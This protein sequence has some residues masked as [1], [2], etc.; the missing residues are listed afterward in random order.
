VSHIFRVPLD[1]GEQQ[2]LTTGEEDAFQ[3][4][5]SPDGTL[6]AFG[7]ERSG[8]DAILIM[9]AEGGEPRV[10]VEGSG[11]NDRPR[12]SPDGS[13]VAFM[14]T[15]GG[16][17]GIWV[18]PSEGGEAARVSPEE[19]WSEDAEWSP[20]GSTIA[21]VSDAAGGLGKLMTAPAGGGE[22]TLVVDIDLV[23]DQ[24][25]SPDGQSIVFTAFG[26]GETAQV[27]R[28]YRVSP[29]GGNPVL[30]TEGQDAFQP[31]WSADGTMIAYA[32]SVGEGNRSDIYVMDADGS[33]KRQLTTHP[34]TDM[35]PRWTPDGAHL[36]FATRRNGSWDIGMVP[37][38]GGDVQV[39]HQ[40]PM[41]VVGHQI[42]PDVSMLYF[43]AA[44]TDNQLVT[45][46]VGHLLRD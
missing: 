5:I 10:L 4:V 39:V 19:A 22:A 15:R 44:P 21:F 12:W 7:A 38:A 33:N 18:V 29:D 17:S 8:S 35:V 9:P 6:L 36:Y 25:W 34:Q 20:D 16:K 13:E 11:D 2:Q 24:D 32:A 43:S 26:S 1:G 37:V 3:P 42:S 31:R 23:G 14:S 28:V 45:V 41:N 27:R 46:D 30:L 40:T